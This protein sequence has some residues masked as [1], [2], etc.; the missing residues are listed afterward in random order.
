M[1]SLRSLV[2]VTLLIALTEVYG[3]GRSHDIAV[4]EAAPGSIEGKIVLPPRPA[5]RM[6]ER[7]DDGSPGGDRPVQA[8]PTVVYLKTAGD[9][10]RAPTGERP[11]L[12]QQDT[13]FVPGALVIAVGTTVE[14]PNRD[15]FF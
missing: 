15:P 4:R 2:A 3:G 7:Y 8:V 13:T 1:V 11:K 6:A 14:F 9:T 12:A 10:A 5:L